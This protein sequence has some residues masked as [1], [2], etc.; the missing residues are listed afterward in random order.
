MSYESKKVKCEMLKIIAQESIQEGVGINLNKISKD[1]ILRIVEQKLEISIDYSK[2]SNYDIQYNISND[3]ENIIFYYY[4][5]N[6]NTSGAK[7][8]A[9]ITLSKDYRILKEEY[10]IELESFDEYNEYNKHI[11]RDL[12]IIYSIIFLVFFYCLIY[13]VFSGLLKICINIIKKKL[14]KGNEKTGKDT[15]KFFRKRYLIHGNRDKE[16]ILTSKELYE[17][18]MYD[19]NYN[20]NW[21]APA[22]ELVRVCKKK[23]FPD[24]YAMDIKIAILNCF[25][26]IEHKENC[27]GYRYFDHP[28]DKKAVQYCYNSLYGTNNEEAIKARKKYL[29]E[30]I[31]KAT[32]TYSFDY[33]HGATYQKICNDWEKSKFDEYISKE[34]IDFEKL[35]EELRKSFKE[36][37]RTAESNGEFEEDKKKNDKSW[38]KFFER[39]NNLI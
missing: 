1:A 6:E 26:N 25:A 7:Y 19:S 21:F 13:I 37:I 39:L 4:L 10:G 36:T 14:L 23:G 15:I 2:F 18:V 17:R 3:G 30:V 22:R 35:S 33:H 9:K 28:E 5:K 32:Y 34:E 20:Y 29:T 27:G 38:K 31:T 12:S 24:N 8:D 11:D 16:Y